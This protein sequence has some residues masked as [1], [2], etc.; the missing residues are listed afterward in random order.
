[1]ESLVQDLRQA[2]RAV[3]ANPL[4]SGVAMLSLA[5]GIGPTTVLVSLIDGLGF[6]P[7]PISRPETLLTVA[8]ATERG[9]RLGFSLE[10]YVDVRD[11]TAS[12]SD[13]AFFA[14]DAVGVSGDALSPRVITA[15]VVSASY[16]STLGVR[17]AIG[18]TFLDGEDRTPGT[19]LVALVSHQFWQESLGADP[20]VLSRRLRLNNVVVAVVGVLPRGFAGTQPVLAPAVWVPT[21]LA[22]SLR[23]GNATPLGGRSRREGQV[24]ARLKDGVTLAQAR[25]ELEALG[26]HLASTYP[27]TNA[28]LSF[29]VEYEQDARRRLLVIAGALS[30]AIVWLILLVACANV[31]GLLLGR[32]DQRRQEIA[33]RVALGASRGRLVRQLLG[34]SLLLSLGGAAAG[35]LVSL[36]MI[37][38]L[39]SLVPQLPIAFN[40]DFR[41]DR[42]VLAVTLLVAFVAAPVAGLLPAAL[43]SRPDV[44]PR[45][46][47]GA[48]A[49]ARSRR[50]GLRN[51]LVVGQIAVSLALLVASALLVRSFLNVRAIDPGFVQ[52]PM[53][54]ATMAPQIVG[55]SD[56][57]T[58]G[59]YRRLLE[60]LAALPG[61]ERAT[62]TR[63]LPLNNLFGGGARLPMS[64]AGFDPAP[65]GEPLR[66]HFDIVAPGYFDTLGIRILRGRDF[67]PRDGRGAGAVVLVNRFMATRFWP[68]Q[69]PLGRHLKIAAGMKT[70]EFVDCE[71]VGVVQDSKHLALTEEPKPFVY[72]PYA[73]RPAGEMTV[74]VRVAG[75]AAAMVEPFRREVAALD[76]TMPTLQVTTLDAH[77][78]FA[79]LAERAVATLVAVLGGLGLFL[80]I[81][82]LYGV[83]SC[84]V[85]RR[86][87][88]IGVR[89]AVGATP[90]DVVREVVRQGG[91]LALVG[92]AVGS[93]LAAAA[94]RVVAG[95]LHGVRYWDPAT[96]GTT[97][98]L[99]LLVALAGAY[100][101][102][103]RAS[104]VD[105]LAALRAE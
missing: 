48:T 75:S 90:H 30:L 2:L 22:P 94:M 69:D 5:L 21:A 71:I 49:G 91:R 64:I 104:R 56:A 37:R 73:Q 17:A 96:Y 11:E 58:E 103:R 97:C 85:S 40:L 92:I 45:L 83:V 9:G 87:R 93:A 68:G 14:P 24:L 1:M 29:V 33:L 43:A 80:S 72:F 53:V 84:L 23:P 63:H 70:A 67:E 82:G 19:H 15:G 105:P 35:L 7:L 18:R 20:Q 74:V 28:K 86:T 34:E 52:R 51:V 101:P 10:D 42:R 13:V 38:L 99:V 59:F 62:M 61:V 39:P 50:F 60:R 31:A 78:R 6:R 32:F 47:G 25:A 81:T 98:L 4:L 27:D 36:W 3:R 44:L 102:A 88:E 16:F 79:T 66:V 12:L 54:F 46:E 95:S 77:M 65:G 8:A 41:L 55:Y 57:Q 89:M 100:I 26:S 76:A